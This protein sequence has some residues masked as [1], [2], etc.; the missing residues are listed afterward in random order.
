MKKAMSLI[1]KPKFVWETKQQLITA[2]SLDNVQQIVKE[3]KLKRNDHSG[4]VMQ[5]MSELV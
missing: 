3:H 5:V 2:N 1:T 4:D